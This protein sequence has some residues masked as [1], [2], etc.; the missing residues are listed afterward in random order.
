MFDPLTAVKAFVQHPSVSTDPDYAEGMEGARN[1]IADLL[2]QL[3]CSV[4]II[5]TP[6]HPIVLAQRTGDASW[7]HI[8]I[9][10][11]YDVQPPD[12]LD[13]WTTPPF[14][15]EVRKGRLYGRGAA[16]N[17]GPLMVHIAAAGHLLEER[18]DLPLRLTFVIEGEEEVGSPSFKTFLKKYR[19]RIRGDFVLLSDTGSPNAEQIV[20]TTGLRG[21][22]GLEVELTGP[23]TDLHS[24]IHGGAVENPIKALCALCASL[25]TPDGQVTLPGFYDDVRTIH[26]WE[27]QELTRM[28]QSLETYKAL[29]G[30]KAFP[31]AHRLSPFEAVRFGP[32]VEFNGITGGY[33]G[34]GAKTII[35]SKAS[36]KITCRLVPDQDPER[37]Q[38]QLIATLHERCPQS[39]TIQCTPVPGGSPYSVV[40]PG[41]SN[42]P[43][44]Q[45]PLLSEAFREAETAV[46]HVFGHKPLF[47]REGG[48]VPVIA[49]FKTIAGMDSLMIGVFTPA[50][51]LHAPNESF[52]LSIME[53]GIKVSRRTLSRI[54]AAR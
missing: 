41:R 25:H 2:G 35:P 47:L 36:V 18:P 19:D 24:G 50:D 17:K 11:H 23:R 49:D 9:Y 10:G 32:T 39:V 44:D 31:T 14:K 28:Q 8:V 13:L 3:G 22:T 46:T 54:A 53:R 12:P 51:N 42:T 33:Q 5:A 7:P 1:F 38:Q 37:I 16:D 27:K 20:I 30:V 45:P 26:D 6:R 34:K 4:E 43:Q 52:D 48:S 29:L 21:L 15:P 40:P